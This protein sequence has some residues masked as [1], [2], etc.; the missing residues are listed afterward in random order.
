MLYRKGLSLIEV[1]A[2]LTLIAG[3]MTALLLAQSRSVRQLAATRRSAQTHDLAEALILQ[4]RADPQPIAPKEGRS[5][6]DPRMRWVRA[7]TPFESGGRELQEVRLRVFTL[8][9]KGDECVSAE[10]LWWEEAKKRE[11]KR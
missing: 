7:V 10:Y 4:W 6:R 5:D 9:D 1:L 2:S 3:A 8:D 11:S